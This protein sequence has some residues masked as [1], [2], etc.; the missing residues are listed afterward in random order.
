MAVFDDAGCFYHYAKF[1]CHASF[2][3]NEGSLRKIFSPFS[4]TKVG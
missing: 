2:K 3:Y 4:D 1:D